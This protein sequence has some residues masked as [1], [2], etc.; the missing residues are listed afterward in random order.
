[1]SSPDGAGSRVAEYRLNEARAEDAEVGGRVGIDC[2]V[3]EEGMKD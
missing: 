2:F 1:M 3:E